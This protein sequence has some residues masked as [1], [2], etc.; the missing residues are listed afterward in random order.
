MDKL[1]VLHVC[2]RLILAEKLFN[3]LVDELLEAVDLTRE[4]VQDGES[5]GGA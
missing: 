3:S 2:K 1:R 5:N 4:E